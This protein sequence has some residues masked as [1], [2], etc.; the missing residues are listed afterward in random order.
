MNLLLCFHIES[1]KLEPITMHFIGNKGGC[2]GGTV[3]G[4]LRCFFVLA[5][6][7]EAAPNSLRKHSACGNI[8]HAE[9]FRM[10]K[11]SASPIS[12]FQ[13]IPYSYQPIRNLDS[14]IC[15]AGKIRIIRY[16]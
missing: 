14:K 2:H 5:T 11:H 12:S 13:K 8:P 4:G 3:R 7:V 9:T 6:S 10:R 15:F 1:G 16:R